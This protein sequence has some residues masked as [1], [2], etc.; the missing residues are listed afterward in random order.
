MHRARSERKARAAV[1]RLNRFRAVDAL[2]SGDK[3]AY[4]TD[5]SVHRGGHRTR[6]SAGCSG[7]G[8]LRSAAHIPGIAPTDYAFFNFCGSSTQLYQFTAQQVESSRLEALGDLGFREAQPTTRLPEGAVIST[9]LDARRT[10]CK[11]QN[12]AAKLV[13]KCANRDRPRSPRR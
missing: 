4:E 6:I 11:D 12:H 7:L 2:G 1:R 5:F 10:A 9:C 8:L 13:D 3:V